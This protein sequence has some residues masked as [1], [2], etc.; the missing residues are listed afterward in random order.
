M[1]KLELP[2]GNASFRSIR[3]WGFYYVDKTSHIWSL[4]Q[5]PGYY[6]LSRPRRFGKSL[7]VSTLKELFEGNEKLFR[8]LYIHDRWDWKVRNPVVRLSLNEELLEAVSDLAQV[9]RIKSLPP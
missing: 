1:D 9:F 7:L 2:V 6:F 4:A 8:G 3:D 5:R